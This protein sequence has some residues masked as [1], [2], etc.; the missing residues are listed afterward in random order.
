VQEPMSAL[1]QKRTLAPLFRVPETVIV[2]ARISRRE[3]AEV[4]PPERTGA[5][6]R[7]NTFRA[8]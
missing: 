8:P 2:L 5:I 3:G 1:G 4:P 7:L 6:G